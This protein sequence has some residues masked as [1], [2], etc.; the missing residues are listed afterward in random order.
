MVTLP[1]LRSYPLK[2]MMSEISETQ[3]AQKCLSRF[4]YRGHHGE[5]RQSERPEYSKNMHFF[6]NSTKNSDER[7]QKEQITAQVE[8]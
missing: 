2:G 4:R 3:K 6:M 5:E 7:V 8:N 1:I